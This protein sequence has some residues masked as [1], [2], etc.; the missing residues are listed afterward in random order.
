V[1]GFSPAEAPEKLVLSCEATHKLWDF[2]ELSADQRASVAFTLFCNIAVD[3][4]RTDDELAQQLKEA[5]RGVR[6]ARQRVIQ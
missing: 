3:G 5:L 4:D 2:F 6:A 1:K